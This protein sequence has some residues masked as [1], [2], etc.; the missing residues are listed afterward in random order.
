MSAITDHDVIFVYEQLK[1]RY[2]LSLTTTTAFDKDFTIDCPLIVGQAH[3]QI[4]EL[5]AYE[6]MFILD[7]LNRDHTRGTHWHPYE[8][9]DAVRDIRE[10][11]E[12]RSNYKMLPLG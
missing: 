12:G 7:V 8:I 3:G 5:Y 1:D 10:F 11:M 6:G 9:A 4:I 2:D